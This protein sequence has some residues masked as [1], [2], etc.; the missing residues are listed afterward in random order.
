[1]FTVFTVSLVLLVLAAVLI[2]SHRRSWHAAQRN[3]ALSDHDRRFARSQYRRRTQASGII[4]A[5]GVGIGLWPVVPRTPAAM[6]LY[7]AA[8]IIACACIM[9][10]AVLDVW[11]TSQHL[12]R[13][14]D[15]ELANEIK[16]A[17][18]RQRAGTPLDRDP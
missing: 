16:R 5:M 7:V 18:K 13:L 3:A 8:L 10:L 12:R 17:I 4:A 15:D 9:L 1:M 14:H 11:A 2:D 6:T